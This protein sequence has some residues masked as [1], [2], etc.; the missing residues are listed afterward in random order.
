MKLPT[1]FGKCN[2]CGK[3]KFLKKVEFG[4]VVTS[5]VVGYSIILMQECLAIMVLCIIRGYAP[6]AAWLTAAVTASQA[7][8]A[9]AL[10]WYLD[11]SGKQN[12]E[13]GITFETAK[14]KGFMDDSDNIDSPVI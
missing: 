4:K 8:I 12:S 14:A 2:G 5:V 3:C 13:G 10:K 11:Y 9:A 1:V 6:S 7:T